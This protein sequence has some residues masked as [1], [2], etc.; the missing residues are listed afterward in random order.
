MADQTLE[1]DGTPE[2]EEMLEII[3]SQCTTIVLQMYYNA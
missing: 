1:F 2:K 3:I